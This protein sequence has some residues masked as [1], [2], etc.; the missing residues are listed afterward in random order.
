MDCLSFFK[1]EAICRTYEY[2]ID[3]LMYY[4][5]STKS[6][7]NELVLL[8][9]DID[10]LE[11][12]PP[13]L[14]DNYFLNDENTND[15]DPP[16]I[17][18]R[19]FWLNVGIMLPPSWGRRRSLLNVLAATP[20][21]IRENTKEAQM[22]RL[23]LY[24]GGSMNFVKG[25]YVGGEVTFLG[26]LDPDFISVMHIL[27]HLKVEL[28]YNNITRICIKLGLEAFVDAMDVLETDAN[29][30]KVINRISQSKKKDDLHIYLEHEVDV[31]DYVEP[32]LPLSPLPPNIDCGEA[33]RW[34]W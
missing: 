33:L 17:K 14:H 11:M 29:V 18:F 22:V 1:L 34:A 10:V 26:D 24:Q 5:H 30:L 31:P 13:S 16:N 19:H 15:E 23:L 32:P 28:K 4:V 25:A 2:T 27:K 6:L 12:D 21:Q 9:S 7:D 20:T 8:K 3:D